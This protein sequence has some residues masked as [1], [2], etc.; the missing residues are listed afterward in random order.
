MNG[1]SRL[2]VLLSCITSL[3][4]C[5]PPWSVK[6]QSFGALQSGGPR[7]V[8]SRP[9]ESKQFRFVDFAK[10]S[11]KS[12]LGDSNTTPTRLQALAIRV[13][14]SGITPASATIEVI[15][16]DILDDRSGSACKGC[17]LAAVSYAGAVGAESGQKPG[18]DLLTC[19]IDAKLD[20]KSFQASW[21]T[22]L[23][24]WVHSTGR[25]RRAR[26]CCRSLRK[27]RHRYVVEGRT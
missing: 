2:L 20:G 8:D 11:Y 9:E 22:P 1:V 27:P 19:E 16:F 5:T 17:A 23:T 24:E 25:E 18:D 4:G 12:Y 10:L 7:I 13:G 6:M 15:R 26:S 21:L 14:A 3:A